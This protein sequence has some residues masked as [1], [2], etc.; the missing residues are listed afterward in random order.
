M[1]VL[2][3]NTLL[4]VVSHNDLSVLSISVM[5]FKYKCLDRGVG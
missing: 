5:S 1:S 4:K 3:V 2:F